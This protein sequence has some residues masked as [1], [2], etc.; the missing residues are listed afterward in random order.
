MKS[1]PLFLLE[2]R[3]FWQTD[4]FHPMKTQFCLIVA[5]LVALVACKPDEPITPDPKDDPNP[6]PDTCVLS[7][8]KILDISNVKQVMPHATGFY[9]WVKK[10]STLGELHSWDSLQGTAELRFTANNVQD[11]HWNGQTHFYFATKDSGIYQLDDQGNQLA[12]YHPQNSCLPYAFI[13]TL[14][15]DSN[16]IIWCGSNQEFQLQTQDQHFAGVGLIRFDPQTNQ[17]TIYDTTNSSISANTVFQVRSS[18]NGLW[19]STLDRWVDFPIFNDLI[20]GKN[21]NYFE[22][23]SFFA[24]DPSTPFLAKGNVTHL[25]TWPSGT[26]SFQMTKFKDWGPDE[27]FPYRIR[28]G[29]PVE[30]GPVVQSDYPHYCFENEAGQF[31]WGGLQFGVTGPNGTPIYFYLHQGEQFLFD[32]D[33][34]RFQPPFLGEPS[35]LYHDPERA[36]ILYFFDRYSIQQMTINP[37]CL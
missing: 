9:L 2:S 4:S 5:I 27:Y 17:C 23:E 30:S 6:N 34:T 31:F 12:H 18:G 10:S 32:K 15:V 36:S 20:E 28:P 37:N 14:A 1:S 25:Q 13:N 21:L 33:T 26:V 19:L 3:I 35:T 22:N 16:G 29:G 8:Q 7:M 11:L 24:F